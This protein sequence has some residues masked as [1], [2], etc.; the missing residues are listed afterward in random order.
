MCIRGLSCFSLN[1]CGLHKFGIRLPL[2]HSTHRFFYRYTGFTVVYI[3]IHKFT[4]DIFISFCFKT[5]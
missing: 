5:G 4:S 2:F 1:Y 3:K